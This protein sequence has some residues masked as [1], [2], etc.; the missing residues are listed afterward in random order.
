MFDSLTYQT[1]FV[2]N[3]STKSITT[4]QQQ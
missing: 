1:M 2:A 3:I 4:R